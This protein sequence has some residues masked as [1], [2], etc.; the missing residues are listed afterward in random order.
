MTL[1]YSVLNSLWKDNVVKPSSLF[2]NFLKNDITLLS[3]K[4]SLKKQDGSNQVVYF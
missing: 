2:L 4:F 1:R 3:S